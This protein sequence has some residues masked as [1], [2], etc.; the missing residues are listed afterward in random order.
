MLQKYIEDHRL[1]YYV[2]N[3]RIDS[4]VYFL[5]CE[6]QTMM[7]KEIMLAKLKKQTPVISLTENEKESIVN[8]KL[9]RPDIREL[10]YKH[11]DITT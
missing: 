10:V 11:L 5:L 8:D 4:R 9:G 6:S 7:H 2:A 3:V 1:D